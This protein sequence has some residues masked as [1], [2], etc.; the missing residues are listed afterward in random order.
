MVDLRCGVTAEYPSLIW[1]LRKHHR[2]KSL[3]GVRWLIVVAVVALSSVS[4]SPRHLPPDDFCFSQKWSNQAYFT[5][6]S[7][8]GFPDWIHIVWNGPQTKPMPLIWISRHP[9]KRICWPERNVVFSKL[10]IKQLLEL[11]VLD[12]VEPADVPLLGR[13][14]PTD[15]GISVRRGFSKPVVYRLNSRRGCRYLRSLL[16]LRGI[17]WTEDNLAPFDPYDWQCKYVNVPFR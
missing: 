3:A 10:E 13:R 7:G 8:Q 14:Y 1:R 12:S 4:A 6:V 15:F 9:L 17:P 5:D 2:R 11:P 16:R